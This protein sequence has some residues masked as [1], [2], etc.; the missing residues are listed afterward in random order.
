MN[1]KVDKNQHLS[2]LMSRAEAAHFLGI[3]AQTLAAWARNRRYDLPFVRVGGRV[4]Y[5]WVELWAF[6][7]R[8]S[9]GGEASI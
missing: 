1:T 9:V 2:P 6:I 8:N 5:R 4:M 7:D 3:S